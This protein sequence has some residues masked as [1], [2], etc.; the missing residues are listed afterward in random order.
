MIIMLTQ[1]HVWILSRDKFVNEAVRCLRILDK[2]G[3]GTQ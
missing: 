3:A 2:F 1:P